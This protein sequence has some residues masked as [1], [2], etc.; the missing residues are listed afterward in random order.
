MEGETALE[1]R[2]RLEKVRKAYGETVVLDNVNFSAK[3]GE[4]VVIIGRSG[5][6]KSTLLRLVGGL[7]TPDAG[8]IEHGGRRLERMTEA[9]RAAFRRREIG[10]V[11]QFFNL[12]PTLTVA[13]NVMLPLA[14]NGIARTAAAARV[15]ALLAELGLDG[16]GPRFPEEL[17]GGEQQRVAIA[18]AVAHR[19]G[20]VLADE[21]TGNLD[22]ETAEL[23]LGLLDE[24]CRTCGATLVMATH[25]REVIGRADRVLTIRH[26]RLTRT[27]AAEDAGR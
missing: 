21:P 2:V 26:G 25:S 12:I 17:S 22:L 3:R 19:P 11:F 4:F 15:N 24:A 6:G 8:T 13:E 14:L 10:F 20:L 1:D 5:S 27:D 23:V 9:E 16:A 18:R 7:E